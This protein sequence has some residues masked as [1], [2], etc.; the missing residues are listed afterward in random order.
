[1]PAGIIFDKSLPYDVV[2]TFEG[3]GLFGWRIVAYL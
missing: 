3:Y 1:M 2:T